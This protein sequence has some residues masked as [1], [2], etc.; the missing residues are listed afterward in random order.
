[1]ST[2]I[3]ELSVGVTLDTSG[4][5]YGVKK[6]KAQLKQL[7]K[8][9]GYRPASAA[10]RFGGAIGPGYKPKTQHG[11]RGGAGGGFSRP[12]MPTDTFGGGLAGRLAGRV[13]GQALGQFLGGGEVGGM[14]AKAGPAGGILAGAAAL[15]RLQVA[16]GDFAKNSGRTDAAALAAGRFADSVRE[17]GSGLFDFARNTA[18]NVLGTLNRAGEWFGA[19]GDRAALDTFDM[20]QRGAIEQTIA[21]D[22]LFAAND[23]AKM[24]AVQGQ[25]AKF[26]RDRAFEGLDL[27]TQE[28]ILAGEVRSL[29][30]KE[31]FARASKKILE[32]DQLRLEILQKE[33]E[34]NRVGL[35]RSREAAA[36]NNRKKEETAAATA[37]KVE[38]AVETFLSELNLDGARE[39]AA[40]QGNAS[41]LA[42]NAGAS[43]LGGVAGD[44]AAVSGLLRAQGRALDEMVSLLRTMAEAAAFQRN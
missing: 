25:S 4:V 43:S 40:M 30:V 12:N 36:E 23:P 27:A 35:Q 7:D 3:G 21:R 29:E 28:Q 38:G 8:E 31:K 24:A 1:M 37:A 13:G 15:V 32:A 14:L 44:G 20:A 26:T 5:D 16:I 33:D 2:S 18:V 34:L 10:L 17:L 22:K 19:G 9:F 6:A 39:I 42:V 11:A 41:A